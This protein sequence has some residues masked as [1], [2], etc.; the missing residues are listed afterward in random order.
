MSNNERA[1]AYITFA[2][3]ENVH[4]ALDNKVFLVQPADT[5]HQP[6]ENRVES[7]NEEVSKENYPTTWYFKFDEITLAEIQQILSHIGPYVVTLNIDSGVY[8]SL[9]NVERCVQKF[10]QYVGENTRELNLYNFEGEQ[11]EQILAITPILSRLHVLN[12]HDFCIFEY[13][14]D[15]VLYVL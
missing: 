8:D 9:L 6:L 2:D 10:N 3:V 7:Y 5:C 11:C 15:L 1:E 14:I 4:A 12:I 13:K